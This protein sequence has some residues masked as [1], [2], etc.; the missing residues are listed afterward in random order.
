MS[1]LVPLRMPVPFTSG[2]EEARDHRKEQ[3]IVRQKQMIELTRTTGQ[4][5]LFERN[6]S[7]PCQLLCNH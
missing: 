2:S 6:T 7:M 3:Q 5:L 1:T 4:K